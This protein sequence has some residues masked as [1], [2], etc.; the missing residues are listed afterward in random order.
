M[1][2]VLVVV[3]LVLGQ[4]L[5]QAPLAVNQKVIE[6]FRAEACRRTVRRTR[7][8]VGERGG[9]LRT[10]RLPKTSSLQFKRRRAGLVGVRSGRR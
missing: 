10:L 1:W 6:A 7:S 5:S 4:D 3:A 8:P 2:L 9:V